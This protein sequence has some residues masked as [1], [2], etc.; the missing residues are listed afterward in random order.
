MYRL[1]T[2]DVIDPWSFC[3][4]SLILV[5][6]FCSPCT[7]CTSNTPPFPPPSLPLDAWLAYLRHGLPRRRLDVHLLLHVQLVSL[8]YLPPPPAA[9]SCAAA[10]LEATAAAAAT[11]EVAAPAATA[12][13]A[14]VWN[15]LI[16]AGMEEQNGL[17][18]FWPRRRL[19]ICWAPIRKSN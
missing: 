12:V 15:F 3:C 8:R 6:Y 1:K 7:C 9:N 14:T 5:L 19:C 11:A 18:C 2:I 4:W 10:S 17:Q 13:P 16:S